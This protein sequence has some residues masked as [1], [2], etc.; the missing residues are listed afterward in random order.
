M[1]TY[2]KFKDIIVKY[3]NF[4][5]CED[6][7]RKMNIEV[8]ESPLFETTGYYF[9]WLWEAYFTEDGCDTISWWA[10]EYH[11]LEE[12]FDSNGNYI[13]EKMEPGMWDKDENV[14]PMVTIEDLWNEV[15][16]ERREF[17]KTPNEQLKDAITDMVK[18]HIQNAV[19][20]ANIDTIKEA[21]GDMW[22]KIAEF[23]DDTDKLVCIDN[24]DEA[25][26]DIMATYLEDKKPYF[27]AETES[28]YVE[29]FLDTNVGTLLVL[30][31]DDFELYVW[32]G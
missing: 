30:S 32:Q 13:G 19:E 5:K 9:D 12:D 7:L 27:E 17:V 28:C 1:I 3:I 14:I 23:F 15:K 24:T 20:P 4:Y 10:F 18:L 22:D 11:N 16:D 29:I 26:A 8:F 6:Q 21:V 25:L 2:E 31:A